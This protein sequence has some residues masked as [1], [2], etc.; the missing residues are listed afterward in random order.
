MSLFEKVSKTILVTMQQNY[1]KEM[2]KVKSGNEKT[3][4]LGNV[5][6]EQANKQKQQEAK[7]PF[8]NNEK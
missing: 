8:V 3:I 5:N 1:E 2:Q 7:V 6:K 4:Y